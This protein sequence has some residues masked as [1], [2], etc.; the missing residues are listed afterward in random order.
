MSPATRKQEASF[1]IFVEKFQPILQQWQGKV[2]YNNIFEFFLYFKN[3]DL[4]F[5]NYFLKAPFGIS[6][7]ATWFE[8]SVAFEA[9]EEFVDQLLEL[10][11]VFM[12]TM[13]QML[14]WMRNP[15]ALDDVK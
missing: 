4:I 12:V 1:A 6:L 10:P 2:Y 3:F 15:T 14:Q 9:L 13:K 5:E 7:H 8:Q 11:E